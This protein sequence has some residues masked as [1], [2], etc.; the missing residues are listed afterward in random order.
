MADLQSRALLPR[1][2]DEI[3]QIVRRKVLADKDDVWRQAIESETR[4][5]PRPARPSAKL[6]KWL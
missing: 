4:I 6:R 5:V 3:L 1:R 2:G